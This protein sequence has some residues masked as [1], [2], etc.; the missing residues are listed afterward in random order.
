MTTANKI[1]IVRILTI[2]F[3]VLQVVYYVDAGVETYRWM[4]LACFAFAALSDGVDGYIARRYN[5]RSELGAL[6]DPMADKL[7]L[8]SAVVLLSLNNQPH[9][10]RLPLWVTAVIIGRDVILTLGL[11]VIY[12][13]CGAVKV[14]P[15][16]L[17]KA[18]TV[19]QMAA[20]LWI[21]LKWDHQWGLWVAAAAGALTGISGLIYVSEGFRLL[22]S[23]PS[24][25]PAPEQND[26]ESQK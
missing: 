1:T 21:L 5:Q 4:A 24:S 18:A 8:V 13:T 9:L 2:P 16:M 17:G 3:F 6:L 20:V 10:Q 12:Y 26:R 25:G 11:A 23:S 22:S 7:L 14:R 15:H 19:G